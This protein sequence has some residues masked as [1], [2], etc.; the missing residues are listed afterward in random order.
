MNDSVINTIFIIIIK[1]SSQEH[2]GP[3]ILWHHQ[4]RAHHDEKGVFRLE[5]TDV[6]CM[7]YSK[8]VV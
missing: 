5:S 7:Q 3:R 4:I 1:R 8:R 2:N 6:K